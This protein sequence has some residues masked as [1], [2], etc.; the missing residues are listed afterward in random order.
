MLWIVGPC[1]GICAEHASGSG[2]EAVHLAFRNGVGMAGYLDR[3]STEEGQ[4][5][6]CE[7][8]AWLP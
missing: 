8:Q 4:A 7:E 1:R 5:D 6:T 2:R 3:T